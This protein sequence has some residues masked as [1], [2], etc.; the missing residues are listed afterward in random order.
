MAG[1][2]TFHIRPA[3]ATRIFPGQ[4]KL[5]AAR[6]SRPHGPKV[7]DMSAETHRWDARAIT[8]HALRLGGV[9]SLR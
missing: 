3:L 1:G 4:R 5:M 8:K 9:T 6:A 7:A 2:K